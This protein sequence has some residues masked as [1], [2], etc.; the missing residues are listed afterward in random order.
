[1]VKM[2]NVLLVEDSDTCRLV[3]SRALAGLDINL[4]SAVTLAEAESHIRKGNF[5]LVLLDLVLP[6]GDGLSLLNALQS[7]PTAQEMP[8]LLLTTKDDLASKVSAFSLGADD[9]LIKPINP[10][11]LKARVEM[12]LR[13]LV[14]KKREGR[15]LKLGGLRLNIPMLKASLLRE[16]NEVSVDLTA[17]EFK[18]LAFLAQNPDQVFSRAQL[19]KAIWGN[20]TH[21]IDR[22]VDSHVC[23]LRKKIRPY[24]EYIECIPTAGYR[25]CVKDL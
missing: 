11:E 7:D 20:S 13:K 5:D 22:T 23:G 21:V 10:I 12:R 2:Y 14:N 3:A 17:K 24:S 15:V 19:M 6:D 8:V 25:L 9:Y 4:V 1:M 16:D 18:I